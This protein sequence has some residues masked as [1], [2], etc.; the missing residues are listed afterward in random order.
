MPLAITL[1]LCVCVWYIKEDFPTTSAMYSLGIY[2]FLEGM[3]T[4]GMGQTIR[5]LQSTWIPCWPAHPTP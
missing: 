3:V 1:I 2:C 5:T 4:V